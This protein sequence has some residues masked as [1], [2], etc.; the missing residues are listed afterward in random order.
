MME[1]DFLTKSFG[2]KWQYKSLTKDLVLMGHSYGGTTALGSADKC[3]QAKAVIG[4]DPWF[5]PYAGDKGLKTGD[6]QECLI[7]MTEH[8]PVEIKKYVTPSE[9]DQ[10]ADQN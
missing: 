10:V 8:F 1:P 5:F 6:Y 9:F 7:V 2:K 3:F 4:L